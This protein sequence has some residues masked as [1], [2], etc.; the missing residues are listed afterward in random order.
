MRSAFSSQ[1]QITLINV[2]TVRAVIYDKLPIETAVL[3]D[4]LEKVCGLMIVLHGDRTRGTLHNT[5]LPRSW[6]LILLK[7]FKDTMNHLETDNLRETWLSRRFVQPLAALFRRI[8]SKPRPGTLFSKN[9]SFIVKAWSLF[10]TTLPYISLAPV[11]YVMPCSLHSF[12]DG[13][14]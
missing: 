1:L 11:S 3:C 7:D 9:S 5:V 2:H 10:R 12:F 14:L 8:Y 4:V 13:P 6:F